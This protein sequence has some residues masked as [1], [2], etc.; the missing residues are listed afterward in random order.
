M[1]V[2]SPPSVKLATDFHSSRVNIELYSVSNLFYTGYNTD[3]IIIELYKTT[4]YS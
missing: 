1:F 3:D 2:K 4:F